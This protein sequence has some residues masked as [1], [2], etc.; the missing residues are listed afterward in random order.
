MKNYICLKEVQEM[1]KKLYKKSEILF[2]LAWIFAYIILASLG[3]NLSTII[4][5]PKIITLP[6]LIALSVILYFFIR[7][8]GL[9]EKYGL[10]KPKIPSEKMLFYLPFIIF[11]ICCFSLIYTYY[12]IIILLSFYIIVNIT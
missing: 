8:N 4:G 11:L 6:I 5:I 10:C 7:K 2:A 1:I 3:D 12:S 9:T